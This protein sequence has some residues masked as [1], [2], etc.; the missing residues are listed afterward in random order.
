MFEI[1]TGRER[2]RFLIG[3]IVGK[4]T[5]GI[6]RKERCLF[7]WALTGRLRF[8]LYKTFRRAS[9]RNIGIGLL[10]V[11]AGVVGKKI[12]QA[13]LLVRPFIRFRWEEVRCMT[14]LCKR[15]EQRGT[16]THFDCY[17]GMITVLVIKNLCYCDELNTNRILQWL[18]VLSSG[19]FE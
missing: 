8:T 14:V 15:K 10:R 17:R 16:L 9:C 6:D 11:M 18:V 3:P 2:R 1:P 12:N 4:R 5:N 13:F 19:E 7:V